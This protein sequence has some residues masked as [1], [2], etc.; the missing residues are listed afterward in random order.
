MFKDV[1]SFENQSLLYSIIRPNYPDKL[2]NDVFENCDNFNLAID[3]GC[4]TG[5]LTLPLST[6]FNK[7]IGVDG[8]ET[9]LKIP[10][11]KF[12]SEKLIF[13]L[14]DAHNLEKLVDK[15]SCDLVIC[16]QSFHW[17]DSVKFF[18]AV[19]QVL[20][21]GGILCLA[22]YNLLRVMNSELHQKSLDEF[23]TEIKPHFEFDR[24]ILERK[25]V[26]YIF[27][28]EKSSTIEY[29]QTN[30]ITPTDFINYLDTFSA[31]RCYNK[32]FGYLENYVD[33][34]EKLKVQ[35]SES[36]VKEL[37]IEIDFF[38]VILKNFVSN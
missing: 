19:G 11:E 6:K 27:P 25:Y 2:I 37:L 35:I 17:F 5:Q 4:G 30:K 23:Y 21:K 38:V 16:G 8:S 10:Q 9:Q 31:Y 18:A 20:N 24:E 33:P 3:V 22:G 7:V 32:K 34:L 29:V 12:S 14:E 1:F 36:E 15:N 28:F 26:D 13:K